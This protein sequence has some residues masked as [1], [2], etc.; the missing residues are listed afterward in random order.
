MM[1]S[2]TS[3]TAR[4][5]L[6]STNVRA[7]TIPLAMRARVRRRWTRCTS[8]EPDE[9]EADVGVVGHPHVQELQRGQCGRRPNQQTEVDREAGSGA[10]RREVAGRSAI[11]PWLGRSV[12]HPHPA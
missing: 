12:G 7:R 6:R 5:I 11:Q 3:E 10:L 8:T 9:D 2:R 1:K 4:R